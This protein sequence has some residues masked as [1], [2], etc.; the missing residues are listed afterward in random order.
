MQWSF[1]LL[2]D[3][4]RLVLSKLSVFAGSFPIRSA[5]KVARKPGWSIS[6]TED[7][8][9]SLVLKSLLNFEIVHGTEHYRLLFMTRDYAKT[10][11]ADLNEGSRPIDVLAEDCLDLVQRA[12]KE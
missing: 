12:E 11:L 5:I 9:G 6:K 10:V 4:E 8:I 7:I 3:D 1:S 2:S